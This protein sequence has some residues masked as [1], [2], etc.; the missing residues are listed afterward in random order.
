MTGPAQWC[1][2]RPIGTTLLALALSVAGAIAYRT[3]PVAP[4]PKVDMP[5]IMVQASLPGASPQTMAA[6]VAAPLERRF[7][8]IAGLDELTSSSA[9]GSTQ[10]ALQFAL[11]RDIEGAA[12][13]TQAA[14]MAAAGDLPSALPSQPVARKMNPSDAPIL[15]FAVTSAV[16]DLAQVYDVTNTIIAPRMAQVTGVGQVTVAG[17][18]QPAVRVQA[19]PMRL[20]HHNLTLA[21]V[22]QALSTTNAAQ[23]LGTLDVGGQRLLIEANDQLFSARDYAALTL[24]TGG[25]GSIKLQDVARVADD[26]EN[27]RVAAWLDGKR[28]ILLFVRRQANANIIDTIA[29]VQ[30]TLPGL[31][32]ALPGGFTVVTALD[33]SATIAQAVADVSHT[34][35]LTIVCVGLVVWLFLGDLR[36]TLVPA[37]AVPL[38]ILGTFCA[39]KVFGFSLNNLSLMALTVSTGFVVDDAIVVTEN[40]A[41]RLSAG[42]K[43]LQAALGGAQD[44]SFTV[45]SMTV[46]LLAVFLPLML[47]GGV[48]GRM[49]HEFAWTMGLAVLISMVVSLTVTPMMCAHL[50]R[51]P[52]QEAPQLRLFTTLDAAFAQLTRHY[53]RVLQQATGLPKTM[54]AITLLA[55]G[56]SA[57]L[58]AALPKG[59]FPEQDTGMLM[60]F[61]E[62]P[63]D[64]SFAALRAR[65]EAV[66]RLVGEDEAVRHVVSSLGAG[67][68]GGA[69][70]STG[71]LFVAL[72]DRRPG[73]LAAKDVIA[74]L[75]PKLAQVPGITTSL[76]AVQDL[77]MGGRGG[78]A[79]YQVAVHA[80]DVAQLRL[81]ATRLLQ[82]LRA[83]PE[84]KDVTSDEQSGGQE[85]QLLLDRDRA[86]RVGIA[87]L[88]VDAAL[89][90]A[91][92]QAQVATVYGSSNAYRVVLE[93]CPKDRA[94]PE[95]IDHLWLR[96]AGQGL[97]PM[98]QVGRRQL[99]HTAL[100]INHEGESAATTVSFNLAPHVA[101]GDAVAAIDRVQAELALPP[102]VS[103]ELAGT[104]RAYT[105]STS[106][107]PW[108]IALALVVVY[109]VLGVLYE[110]AWHPVTILSTLP[111]AGVGALVALWSCGMPVDLIAFVGIMLLIGIVKKNAIM[112]VDVAQVLQRQQGMAARAAIVQA[113]AVRFRP[114]MMTTLAALFGAL[115]LALGQGAGSTLRRPLGVSIVGGLLLS[116]AMTLFTTPGV[117]LVV[118]RLGAWM[119]QHIAKR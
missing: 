2:H 4:L 27:D 75:R 61:T 44:I 28:A 60:G 43:P 109:V 1:I 9:L 21:D 116:Q 42:Q 48:V 102:G 114:I 100:S 81:W 97:V 29:Q 10:L 37:A 57:A 13:D 46:S 113:C 22:A 47:M 92:G 32:D 14:I 73:R 30:A 19:D 110:S 87:P 41:R 70:Q 118:E 90:Q 25:A 23:P 15:I 91:F 55:C 3:L 107:Q 95:A 45:L 63:Q 82:G 16:H 71:T 112:M 69:A 5:M 79:Q 62:A 83:L 35:V 58:F 64:T 98:A 53:V 86:A 34:L 111:P 51:A 77:R 52:E 6:S 8:R 67:G 38:S 40:I 84:L 99:G 101:L 89:Y 93:A 59:L 115:P 76:Q 103:V 17:G 11:D 20:T 66:A 74:R 72:D 117:Y 119:R 68:P 80:Q 26:V 36:H 7:G 56:I 33:R 18:Q 94:E 106:K 39:M 12:R 24:G 49:F 65:Q 31:Q 85:V 105:A 50:L 88:A 108:L 54:A 96:G 78:R 104:A